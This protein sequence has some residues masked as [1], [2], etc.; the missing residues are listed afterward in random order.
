[1]A[2]KDK[3][4]EVATFRFGVISE[5]VTGLRLE[6]GEKERLLT[7]KSSKSYRVPYSS[8]TRVSRSTI[9]KWIADYKGSGNRLEGLVPSDRKDQGQFRSLDES[10][11]VVIKEIMKAKGHFTGIA[12]VN[13]LRQR[14]SIGTNEEINMSVLYR[15]L[16]HH[17]L[18]QKES[19]DRRSFEASSPNEMW[20]SD[21]LHGPIVVGKKRKKV[22]SYLIAILDDNS[23]I[24]PHGEFYES[25]RL[26]NM[27]DCLKKAV[28]KRG[29]PQ[30]LYIDNGACF[31][32]INLEQ[33]TASLGIQI[34]HTPPYTPQGRGKV[35]RW[36]RYVR[37]NFFPRC[38]EKTLSLEELNEVFS[39]WV[40]SYHH[41]VHGTTG[42]TPLAKFRKNMKCVRP[43]PPNLLDYFRFIQFRRV[44]KDRTFH[45]NG[46]IYEAPVD[47]IDRRVE[48]KFHRE[49]PEDVEIFFD[50]RSF[51]QANLLDRHVNFYLGR[52]G[53]V[54][55]ATKETKPKSGELFSGD[56][57][58]GKK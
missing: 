46:T 4:M 45:L 8:S 25:E 15:F 3:K 47:L 27:K 7:E 56:K 40:E 19:T 50:G 39:D 16:K 54:T 11:Q 18:Q 48:L 34:I 44:K 22:K 5:F 20:Q 53:K 31:K 35:E 2:D 1:M 32:A 36:F 24:I 13:A 51:G 33:V 41:K 21:V 10:L 12:L 26:E 23:R 52:N 28:E 17:K 37:E 43:A 49:T 55:S 6:Y 29:L 38:D 57:T 58:G 30:K 14:G 42:E 9:K